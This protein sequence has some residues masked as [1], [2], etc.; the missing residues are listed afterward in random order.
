[1]NDSPAAGAV[2]HAG[3]RIEQMQLRRRIAVPPSVSQ[4]VRDTTGIDAALGHIAVEQA[5]RR[6][7]WKIWIATIERSPAA[8]LRSPS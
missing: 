7:N 6:A 8:R 5:E 1:M 3:K 2:G 4:Q